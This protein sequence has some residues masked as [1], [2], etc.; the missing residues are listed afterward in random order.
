MVE[1]LTLEDL[2]EE[3]RKLI[4]QL[5]DKEFTIRNAH[6]LVFS[7]EYKELWKKLKILE[8]ISN[9]IYVKEQI[10]KKDNTLTGD[11]PQKTIYITID[12]YKSMLEP[13]K[14]LCN[15][16]RGYSSS[17][18]DV[19]SD[20]IYVVI[21]DKDGNELSQDDIDSEFDLE[22]IKE[23]VLIIHRIRDSLAHVGSIERLLIIFSSELD[24]SMIS[25]TN[26]NDSFDIDCNVLPLS[27]LESFWECYMNSYSNHFEYNLLYDIKEKMKDKSTLDQTTDITYDVYNDKRLFGNDIDISN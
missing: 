8:I 16:V 9:F 18:I 7:D 10:I 26:N 12:D 17:S 4:L 2:V 27:I 20:H 1:E 21:T 6:D 19:S 3:Q 11:P 24:D 15:F 14:E 23:N 13:I 5:L 25:F 22:E